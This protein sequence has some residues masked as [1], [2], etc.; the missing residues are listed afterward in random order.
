[1]FD[2]K[3][4]LQHIENQNINEKSHSTSSVKGNDTSHLPENFRVGD[5]GKHYWA[6]HTAGSPASWATAKPGDPG[7]DR[8]YPDRPSY[9]RRE[10]ER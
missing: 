6:G 5:L 2:K 10:R 7:Y 9:T 8:D 1:M 4:L 3:L